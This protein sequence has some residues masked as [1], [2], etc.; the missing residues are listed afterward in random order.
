VETVK[1]GIIHIGG[2]HDKQGGGNSDGI[3]AEEVS[4]RMAT[5]RAFD[6]NGRGKQTAPLPDEKRSLGYPR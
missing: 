1:P 2:T 4:G 6:A 3:A 5:N